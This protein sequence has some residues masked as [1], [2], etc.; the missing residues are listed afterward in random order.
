[1][2]VRSSLSSIPS[3]R[4]IKCAIGWSETS[5]PW[6]KIFLHLFFNVIGGSV[7][8]QAGASKFQFIFFQR[9]HQRQSF[10]RHKVEE[11]HQTQPHYTERLRAVRK[12]QS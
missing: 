7:K 10:L 12:E 8:H 2:R 3:H 4:F 5:L 11:L 6:E 1:M 9:R